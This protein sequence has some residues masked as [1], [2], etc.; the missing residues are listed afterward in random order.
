MYFG[1]SNQQQLTTIIPKNEQLTYS[2][3]Q[4]QQQQEEEEQEQ[5][6]EDIL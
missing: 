3:Q 4:Q 1:R 2:Q 5:E 6:Q